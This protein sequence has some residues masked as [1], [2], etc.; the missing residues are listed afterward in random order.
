MNTKRTFLILLVL[1]SLIPFDA[2]AQCAMCRA[3]LESESSG[4]AAEGINNGIV[5][6]M[7]V[8]YVLVAGLFY[9]IYRKMRA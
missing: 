4:K 9:F 2:D 8:P 6:L 5:Y 3:V 1:I 7:A